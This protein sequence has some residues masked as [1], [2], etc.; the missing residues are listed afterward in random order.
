[1][2][3]RLDALSVVLTILRWLKEI[4]SD[5][6]SLYATAA[7]HKA[8]TCAYKQQ[9]AARKKN[10]SAAHMLG[11][12]PS[13]ISGHNMIVQFH[14]AHDRSLHSAYALAG[15]PLWVTPAETHDLICRHGYAGFVADELANWMSRRLSMCFAA[16]FIGRKAMRVNRE[17]I[18]RQL[19]KMKYSRDNAME[20]ASMIYDNAQ[21]LL[22][23]GL[24]MRGNLQEMGG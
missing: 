24:L 5:G 14:P 20:L 21:G 11:P 3:A 10:G 19:L 1:M 8:Q 15:I 13:G 22:Q 4:R 18:I 12:L 9:E 2:L 16:G 7:G 6:G 23:K 17:D